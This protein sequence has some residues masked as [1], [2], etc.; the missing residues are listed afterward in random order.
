MKGPAPLVLFVYNRPAHARRTV[1]AL[2]RNTGAAESDLVVYSD[3]PRPGDEEAVG[4]VRGY[5]KDIRGFRSVTIIEHDGNR[6]LAANIIEG[7]TQT[8]ERFGRVI[9]LEDDIVT[10]PVFLSY[11]N[12]A[13]NLYENDEKVMHVSGFLPRSGFSWLLP[14]T[15]FL[16]FM[17]CW[18]WATWRRAWAKF[19]PDAKMLYDELLKRGALHDYN[20]D[21]VLSFHDQLEANISG[22]IRTWA[23]KWF[24]TIY[25][26]EGLCLYPRESLAQN[27]G[28]DGTGI[29]CGTV[30]GAGNPYEP[31][32]TKR[33]IPVRRIPIRQSRIGRFYLKRF[34]RDLPREPLS[35][36]VM[37]RVLRMR[38]LIVKGYQWMRAK[39]R[40]VGIYCGLYADWRKEWMGNDYGGFYLCMNMPLSGSSVVYSLGVGEDV[41]FDMAVHERYGCKIY[42]FDPT[43]KSIEWV[44]KNRAALPSDL[45][46]F[47]FGIAHYDGIA[48]FYPPENPEHVSCSIVKKESTKEKTFQVPVK[49]LATVMRERRHK[50]IDVLKM[51]VEGAEYDIIEDILSSRIVVGQL[52]VEFH[53]RFFDAGMDKTEAA[54]RKLRSAGFDVAGISPSGMEYTFVNSYIER[55]SRRGK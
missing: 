40:S 52:L 21:G 48:T 46:F 50:I 41:S 36:R 38:Q 1:E 17:S 10:S 24:T 53:H 12:E 31:P 8:V 42:A 5:L 27:I 32:L 22:T 47:D 23:T 4:K 30:L 18:G 55:K 35:D 9:V 20:L 11:M 6:G 26:E 14:P 33:K 3:G 43:P 16:R 15:F 39:W 28:F 19:N 45:I 2:Q 37:R 54:V 13:L 34:Y 49:R 29:H 44:K 25:L 51:D 7:V